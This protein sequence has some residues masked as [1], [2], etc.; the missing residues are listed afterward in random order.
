[1]L[2]SGIIHHSQLYFWSDYT[3]S[4]D[5]TVQMINIYFFFLKIREL[6]VCVT[7]FIATNGLISSHFIFAKA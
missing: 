4:T 3:I 2:L 7:L 6:N 1:M 5:N